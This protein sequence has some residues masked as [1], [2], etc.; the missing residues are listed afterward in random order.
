MYRYVR[1]ARLL[2]YPNSPSDRA[3]IATEPHFDRNLGQW[4]DEIYPE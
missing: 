2:Y 1:A 3:E 4:E